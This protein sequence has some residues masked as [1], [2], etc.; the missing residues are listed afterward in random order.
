MPHQQAAPKMREERKEGERGEPS[1]YRPRRLVRLRTGPNVSCFRSLPLC[2][3]GN[4]VPEPH[5]PSLLMVVRPASGPS[6]C[7]LGLR[8]CSASAP[9]RAWH[10]RAARRVPRL[11]GGPKLAAARGA[12]SPP[13]AAPSH[14]PRPREPPVQP[15]PR[16]LRRHR[17][18]A[19]P[20][21]GGAGEL[22][23]ASRWRPGH[24][25]L[26]LRGLLL[27][28]AAHPAPRS[29]Q[30]LRGLETESARRRAGPRPARARAER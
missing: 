30:G 15:P 3:L 7:S 27:L 20:E 21:G 6:P 12:V 17:P 23:P 13:P 16:G 5:G 2:P 9:C 24:R 4:V 19:R 14:Q 18:S 25:L 28:R 26:V 1:L 8:D 29:A 22:V 11:W 10:A